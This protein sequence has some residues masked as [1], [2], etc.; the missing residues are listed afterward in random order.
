MPALRATAST[1]REFLNRKISGLQGCHRPRP[2]VNNPPWPHAWLP[3]G[4][5]TGGSCGLQEI[6]MP[7]TPPCA[8]SRSLYKH[9]PGLAGRARVPSTHQTPALPTHRPLG[10]QQQRE[11]QLLAGCRRSR[12]WP[13]QVQGSRP[14]AVRTPGRPAPAPP[15]PR[16]GHRHR[17][18][19][20]R[21]CGRPAPLAPGTGG[22]RP[23]QRSGRGSH[24]A[25]GAPPRPLRS[26]A[27]RGRRSGHTVP[28]SG[29]AGAADPARRGP[30]PLSSSS[31]SRDW[32]LSE[33]QCRHHMAAAAGADGAGRSGPGPSRASPTP[34]GG[35]RSPG[36]DPPPPP[37]RPPGDRTTRRATPSGRPA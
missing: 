28:A 7:S 8:P 33:L 6:D 27:A 24:R 4:L 35:S 20:E 31:S 15:P 26:H 12:R 21:A 19:G 37:P 5:G 30:Y 17:P 22:P 11:S 34:A 14:A 36:A 1:H 23:S 25:C 18:A 32:V 13:C 29:R 10:S 9:P 16:R 3:E 2:L